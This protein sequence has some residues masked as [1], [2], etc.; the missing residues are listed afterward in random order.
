MYKLII[1]IPGPETLPDF[2]DHWP[3]F[4][5]QVEQL[6]GLQREAT[7]HIHHVL[8]GSVGFEMVHE[9]FFNSME[10]MQ[11]ALASPQGK[12]AASTLHQMTHGQVSLLLADHREDDMV[13][14]R[15]FTDLANPTHGS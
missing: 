4:L 12:Q 11:Q 15:K 9:L 5:H 8:F 6:P 2:H 13:N 14:I 7:S 3:N 1:L 10:A